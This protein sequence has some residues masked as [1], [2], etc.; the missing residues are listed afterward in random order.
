MTSNYGFLEYSYNP[1]SYSQEYIEGKLLLYG[2][3]KR[4]TSNTANISMWVQG[5]CIF[6]VRE[7]EK[8]ESAGISGIGLVGSYDDL[9][10]KNSW[11][12][13]VLNVP[14][15]G[16]TCGTRIIFVDAGDDDSFYSNDLNLFTVLSEPIIQQNLLNS[17]SGVVYNACTNSMMDF[18]Q[19]LGFKFTSSGE[20]YQVLTSPNN[21]FTI[22]SNKDN[23]NNKIKTVVIDTH[24]IWNVTSNFSLK[25]IKFSTPSQSKLEGFG[26]MSHKIKGYGLIADGTDQSYSIE[27][28]ITEALPGVD[29]IIRM[30]KQYLTIKENMLKTHYHEAE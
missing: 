1:N 19:S 26:K 18:Y 10:I 8:V 12:D 3:T 15:T 9:N 7:T 20:K 25:G 5:L 24:D 16:D 21:R 29:F 6:F 30:R 11:I 22:L 17:V 14:V 4:L 2:F 23:K 27:N 13:N 28:K